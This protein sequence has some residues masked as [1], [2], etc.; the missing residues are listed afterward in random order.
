VK[1]IEAAKLLLKSLDEL[2]KGKDGWCRVV[3]HR[4]VDVSFMAD[5]WRGTQL[6]DSPPRG[7]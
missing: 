3:E 7:W 6:T 4:V 2:A 5:L 1:E